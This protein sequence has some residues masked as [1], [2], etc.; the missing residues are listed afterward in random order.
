MVKGEGIKYSELKYKNTDIFLQ[1]NY[2][3]EINFPW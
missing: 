3:L 1:K 2:S